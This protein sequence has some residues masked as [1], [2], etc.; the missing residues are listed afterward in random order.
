MIA[1]KPARRRMR[2]IAHRRAPRMLANQTAKAPRLREAP[3]SG[4]EQTG[5]QRPSPRSRPAR[6]RTGRADQTGSPGTTT[7]G[8][9]WRSAGQSPLIPEHVVQLRAGASRAGPRCAAGRTGRVAVGVAPLPARVHRAPPFPGRKD[10][11]AVQA[12]ASDPVLAVIRGLPGA[13]PAMRQLALKE[14]EQAPGA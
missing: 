11:P 10:A 12:H 3:G 14:I 9:L 8:S 13:S 4:L 1:H 6:R 2:P 7:F 5:R